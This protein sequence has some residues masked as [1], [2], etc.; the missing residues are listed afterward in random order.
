MFTLL[1]SRGLASLTAIVSTIALWFA[2][3]FTSSSLSATPFS[4][5]LSELQRADSM[6]LKIVRDGNSADVWIRSPGLVRYQESAQKYQIAAGSRLWKIDE[7]SNT[8]EESDSPWFL[9]PQ[10]R[11]DLLSLLA[12]DITD[13]SRL[14]TARPVEQTTRDGRD[15]LIYRTTLPA[16]NGDRSTLKQRWIQRTCSFWRLPHGSPRTIAKVHRWPR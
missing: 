6:Q 3:S 9:S 16:K 14:M 4:K 7:T 2:M 12:S 1:A 11:I 8:V 5:V 10:E 13:A 15:C